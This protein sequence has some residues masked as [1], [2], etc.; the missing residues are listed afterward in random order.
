MYFTTPISYNF[1]KKILTHFH[2]L[3]DFVVPTYITYKD[4]MDPKRGSEKHA[5]KAIEENSVR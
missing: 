2:E 3:R 5:N 4:L 1:K